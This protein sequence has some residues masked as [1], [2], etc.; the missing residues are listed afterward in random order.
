MAA[1]RAIVVVLL[2]A[3]SSRSRPGWAAPG[4]LDASFGT[5]GWATTPLADPG[6]IFALALQPDG[7]IVA[8]G[9]APLGTR[10]V[11]ARYLPDGTPDPGVGSSGVVQ[12]LPAG[13]SSG[14]AFGVVLQPDGR[15]VVAGQVND[16]LSGTVLALI[17]LLPDGGLDASFG[18]AGSVVA[19]DRS[20]GRAVVV[21]GDGRIVVALAQAALVRYLSDGTPATLFGS[22][23]IDT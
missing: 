1:V 12:T 22:A 15:I 4:D 20:G 23:G 11:L 19:P 14:G 2:L 13:R 3:T 5:G 10:I 6:S 21:Q 17:R 18:T 16:P 7:K 8:A 9:Q